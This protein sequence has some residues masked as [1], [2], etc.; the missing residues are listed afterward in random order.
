MF[1]I[2]N[3]PPI[4][5]PIIVNHE[6]VQHGLPR[7]YLPHEP[8]PVKRAYASLEAL[9]MER[10]ERRAW[11][12]AAVAMACSDVDRR[13]IS[14]LCPECPTVIVPNVVDAETYTPNGA[15]QAGRVA[16]HGGLEW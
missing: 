16:V 2:A 11:A 5:V 6:S 13:T 4:S 15:G 10:W 12:R 9:K 8:N 7:R 3:C 1:T 14:R